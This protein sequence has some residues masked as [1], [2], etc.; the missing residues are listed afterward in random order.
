MP[1]NLVTTPSLTRPS[2]PK[3]IFEPPRPVRRRLSQRPPPRLPIS[4]TQVSP[5]RA[6]RPVFAVAQVPESKTAPIMMHLVP[7]PAREYSGLPARTA[8]SIPSRLFSFADRRRRR[9]DIAC[10]LQLSAIS[11]VASNKLQSTTRA[12]PSHVSPRPS[13]TCCGGHPYLLQTNL[14]SGV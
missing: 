2:R 1:H 9:S 12:L 8:S 11:H 14:V 13:L 10:S 4:R 3:A 7:Q 5:Y 6:R